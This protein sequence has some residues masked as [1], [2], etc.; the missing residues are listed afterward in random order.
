MQAQE[1]LINGIKEIIQYQEQ[2]VK[3]IPLTQYLQMM[4]QHIKLKFL[5]ESYAKQKSLQA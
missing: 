1:I 3:H 2:Q 4:Q 5:V